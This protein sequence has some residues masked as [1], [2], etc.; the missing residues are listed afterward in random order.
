MSGDQVQVFVPFRPSRTEGTPT[1]TVHGGRKAMVMAHLDGAQIVALTGPIADVHA[2]L[3]GVVE[4]LERSMQDTTRPSITCPRCWQTS[5]HPQD[6]AH[7]YCGSCHAYTSAEW[8]LR[9]EAHR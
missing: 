4:A 9:A 3:S 2:L 8:W 5:W 1:V 7:G 6:V